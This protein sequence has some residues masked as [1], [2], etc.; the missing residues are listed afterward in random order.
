MREVGRLG[1][2]VVMLAAACGGSPSPA[3]SPDGGIGLGAKEIATASA[4]CTEIRRRSAVVSARCNGGSVEDWLAYNNS[5]DSCATLDRLVARGTVR[6]HKEIAAACLGAQSES[7][8]C[9]DEFGTCYLEAVEGVLGAGAPCLDAY[10]CPVDGT[11]TAAGI[12]VNACEPQTC[13][14]FPTKAGDTCRDLPVC[15]GENLTCV[16]GQCLANVAEGGACGGARPDCRR[17]LHCDATL[18]CAPRAASGPCLD[19]QSCLPTHFCGAGTCTPRLP[20]GAPCADAPTGC[21]AFGSCNGSTFVCEP[22]GHEGQ[23][24]G[25]SEGF[26]SVCVSGTCQNNQD[27]SSLCPGRQPLGSPCLTGDEC[28]SGGC[29]AGVCA[30]CP[31]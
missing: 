17:G 22:A 16:E 28:A 30:T 5:F 2:I 29:Q 8:G 14:L 1:A 4:F 10:E 21:V 6:Y 15:F 23:S 9:F 26:A 31:R 24:C 11:C 12:I 18:T 7:R 25:A 19:D 20:I 3:K 27:G 13:V